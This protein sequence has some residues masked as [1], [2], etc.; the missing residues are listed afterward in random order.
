MF[1]ALC[2]RYRNLEYLYV[3]GSN[4]FCVLVSQACNDVLC[5]VPVFLSVHDAISREATQHNT[6]WRR[7]QDL[8]WRDE[9]LLPLL[10]LLP[11]ADWLAGLLA[12]PWTLPFLPPPEKPC[13]V[14]VHMHRE[15]LDML[16][17]RNIG[18]VCSCW[19]LWG[20]LRHL[21]SNR[22][23]PS[24]SRIHFFFLLLIVLGGRSSFFSNVIYSCRLG[25]PR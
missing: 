6:T 13:D 3:Y 12:A 9:P 1:H 7:R 14:S 8:C 18:G 11:K 21:H 2:P 10:P 4:R 19:G 16:M 17:K 22:C 23:S 15:A 20:Q 5:C 24:I 25:I